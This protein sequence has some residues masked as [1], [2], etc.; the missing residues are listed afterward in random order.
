M[1]LEVAKKYSEEIRNKVS[2]LN[3]LFSNAALDGI[4]TEITIFEV[5]TS[6]QRYYYT[7]QAEVKIS[8]TDLDD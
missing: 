8:P 5:N 4:S 6:G 2:E 7:L 3:Q 1:K